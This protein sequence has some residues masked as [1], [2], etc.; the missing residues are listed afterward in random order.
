M[1]ELC[2]HSCTGCQFSEEVVGDSSSGGGGGRRGSPFELV[3]VL[4]V[5]IVTAVQVVVLL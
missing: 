3:S 5:T 2:P 1:G 4:M